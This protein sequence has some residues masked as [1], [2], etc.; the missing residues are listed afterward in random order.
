MG[1]SAKRALDTILGG[2]PSPEPDEQM[3]VAEFHAYIMQPDHDP[4]DYEECARRTARAVL[5]FFLED[6]QRATLPAE[7]VYDWDGDPDH[8]HEG[9]KPEYVKAL[10]LYD[11]LKAETGYTDE[12]GITGFQWGWAV[13]AARRCVELGPLPNPAIITIGDDA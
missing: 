13:N 12:Y 10:G 8:G 7:T 2:E 9:M 11:V 6:P 5:V 3:S 1:V 4:L